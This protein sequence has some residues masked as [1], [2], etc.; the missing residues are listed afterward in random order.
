[1]K[2]DVLIERARRDMDTVD[3]LVEVVQAVKAIRDDRYAFVP[4]LQAGMDGV[5][6]SA[7]LFRALFAA[8]PCDTEPRTE[9]WQKL[10]VEV[11]GVP[12]FCVTQA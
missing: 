11:D 7:E 5:Q 9:G 6:I 3:R 4:I 8:Q 2:S 1:M 12:V 10:A